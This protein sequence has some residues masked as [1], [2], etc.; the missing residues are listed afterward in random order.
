MGETDLGGDVMAL[1]VLVVGGGRVGGALTR[2][3]V[4]GGHTVTVVDADADAAARI[5]ERTP[6]ARALA[7]DGTDPAVLESAGIRIAD[8]VAAMTGDDAANVL[9]CALARREFAVPRTIARIVDPDHR[10]LFSGETGVDVA[11]DQADLIAGLIVEEMSM[12][13][14]ASL[15]KLRRGAF[16]LIEER[17]PPRSRAIGRSIEQLGLP[18]DCVLVAVLR[19]DRALACHGGL[20]L[21][22]GD[23]VL[24][25][26]HTGAASALPEALAASTGT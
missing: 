20:V 19:G 3:L 10:W 25:I 15:L 8:I 7:A 2:Q 6:E 13:E 17:V 24:A 16:T 18:A 23:E 5:E 11:V 9:V 12:G 26:V 22:A 4:D 21:Q 1:T 14:V